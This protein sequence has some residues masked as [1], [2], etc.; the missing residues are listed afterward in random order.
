M[1]QK[2]DVHRV[3]TA[4]TYFYT[5]LKKMGAVASQL[6]IICKPLHSA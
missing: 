4:F 1:T 3:E 2:C 6:V 5:I